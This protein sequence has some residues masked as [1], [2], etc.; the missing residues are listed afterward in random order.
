MKK[1]SLSKEGQAQTIF[2]KKRILEGVSIFV[3][4]SVPTKEFCKVQNATF[5]E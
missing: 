2:T 3:F 1:G 5:Y 4:Y